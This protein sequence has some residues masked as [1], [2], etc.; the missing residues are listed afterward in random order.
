MLTNILN[1]FGIEG[2]TVI[3]LSSIKIDDTSVQQFT[4]PT[5]IGEPVSMKFII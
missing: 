1:L 4:I 3:L 5:P 2:H